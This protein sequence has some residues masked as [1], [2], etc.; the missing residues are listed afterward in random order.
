MNIEVLLL[1]WF[2]IASANR[3]EDET[4]GDNWKHTPLYNR[5]ESV[6][7]PPHFDV[8]G[9]PIR[10]MIA[11]D[12]RKGRRS[13]EDLT[14]GPD[15][16]IDVLILY[17]NTPFTKDVGDEA[18]HEQSEKLILWAN[19]A[20]ENSGV[21][22]AGFN[23]A[24]TVRLENYL[25]SEDPLGRDFFLYAT[26]SSVVSK[27][28]EQYSADL[29]AYFCTDH[30][31]GGALQSFTGTAT[32]GAL[33]NPE[34]DYLCDFGSAWV[35]GRSGGMHPDLV[36]TRWDATDGTL[37]HEMGHN[38]GCSHDEPGPSH[39]ENTYSY[40]WAST[41]L[42][43]RGWTTEWPGFFTLMSG[44]HAAC[45]CTEECKTILGQWPMESCYTCY[46]WD[47]CNVGN[48]TGEGC[49]YGGC[50]DYALN[51]FSS[52]NEVDPVWG[53]PLGKAEYADNASQLRAE[54][55]QH[56][57][58]R[59]RGEVG[60]A[61]AP[62]GVDFFECADGN[63][64]YM[65]RH[66][67][68]WGHS[69]ENAGEKCPTTHIVNTDQYPT[70]DLQSYACQNLCADDDSCVGYQLWY[71]TCWLRFQNTGGVPS[72]D[73]DSWCA[74]YCA[75]AGKKVDCTSVDECN[76]LFG[77]NSG[78]ADLGCGV[79][80]PAP[81][82]CDNQCG[83]TKEDL[84]C[85][86]GEAGPSGCDNKCGSTK[87]DLGCGCG[88]AG[89]SGCDNKC[90]SKKVDE[91]CGCGITCTDNQAGYIMLD[92]RIDGVIYKSCMEAGYEDV[93]TKSEC[94]RAASELG[95]DNSALPFNNVELPSK[96]AVTSG[97][98]FW[99]E[100]A[101]AT[102]SEY[103]GLHDRPCICRI[104]I[105]YTQL[106]GDFRCTG[107]R[108]LYFGNPGSADKCRALC[109]ENDSCRYYAQWNTGHC[110]TYSECPS[111]APDGSFKINRFEK[112]NGAQ[113]P[114]CENEYHS[115]TSCNAW[116]PYCPGGTRPGYEDWMERNCCKACSTG[117]AQEKAIGSS[118]SSG[119]PPYSKEVLT[120][121][122]LANSNAFMVQGLAILGVFSTLAFVAQRILRKF[123]D[124]KYQSIA[125]K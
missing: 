46:G 121:D 93:P 29:V 109:D 88:E 32:T 30:H 63:C 86:C 18:M 37:A 104:T 64:W 67:F 82:G 83:S 56:A 71:G 113:I 54:W 13:L 125:D 62:R 28:R 89:P 69:C 43:C 70:A 117:A 19:Y 101:E 14:D 116:K 81:S 95:Q 8:N 90:G 16:Q 25:E 60:E 99:N 7:L 73:T 35:D 2:A 59:I 50:G 107:T 120:W 12:D 5:E 96:C 103:C 22:T 66:T 23:L 97:S 21:I 112:L 87:E 80:N 39:A 34:Y 84:G 68:T 119:H 9:D 20:L 77:E 45:E 51:A 74:P 58:F 24:G 110:E 102:G 108:A 52:P 3:V 94:E 55:K 53:A 57:N 122:T 44:G 41:N 115:D 33:G 85:G 92:H 106:D 42:F 17:G 4:L 100:I 124:A 79:G 98:L 36:G 49:L 123:S 38:L 26:G 48:P 15:D 91:G 10:G 6:P 72:I 61:E 40:G 27:L 47:C 31:C 105:S 78:G 118:T 11:R 1:L 111:T 114:A 76:A 75:D 65:M